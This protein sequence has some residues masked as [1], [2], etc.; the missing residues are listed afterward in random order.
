MKTTAAGQY[1]GYSLQQLR[2]CHHLFKALDGDNVSLEYLDDIAVHRSDGTLLLEQD[3]SALTGNPAADRCE[4]LW[5]AFANW[6]DLCSSDSI[7][8]AET[9]FQL[10]VT[11][12]KTGALVSQLHSAV[13]SATA[14]DALAKIKKLVDP[15]K[16]EIGCTPHVIRFLNAGDDICRV[17]IQR[18][19][20][21]TEINPVESV[22]EYVRAGVPP[23]AV[24]DLTSA[25]VGMARD[26]VDKLIREGQPP[27]V[28]AT[29]FRRLFQTFSQR[30]NL[31]NMLPSK[32]PEPSE[33][34]IVAVVATAPT[35]V[36]QLQAIN[37]SDDMLV[38]AVSDYLR[39]TAD[40]VHWA[41]EGLIIEDSLNDLDVQLIRQH[42]MVRDEI[43]DTQASVDEP[44]RGR[45]L[46]RRCAATT[47]PLEGRTL[48]SHFIAGAFNDLADLRRVGWHPS[49]QT[50]FPME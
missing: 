19:R 21:V 37:A 29:K 35:F 22:R 40:K 6:A 50:L 23:D 14:S 3:K 2:L 39:S 34:A 24:D 47:L 20:L 42:K 15:N 17:I 9:D 27:I 11:P 31:T 46:Y 48:P 28:S 38:T 30:S 41:D 44:G 32:A 49:Y 8:A 33:G 12:A 13:T 26:R 5:K 1:L 18:F 36:R 25:A 43:E 10:Y 7:D 16:L 45:A 4:E